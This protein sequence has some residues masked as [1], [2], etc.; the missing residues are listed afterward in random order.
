MQGYMTLFGQEGLGRPEVEAGGQIESIR[1][2][3]NKHMDSTSVPPVQAALV[4]T[5]DELVIEAEGGP[6]PAVHLRKL[7]DFMR[8]QAKVNPLGPD[9]LAHVRA[10][11]PE[12]AG[13]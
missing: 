11:F 12:Q 3:L 2:M 9:S 4:F 10:S 1:K 7:K 13:A 5:H 8:Q 6:V